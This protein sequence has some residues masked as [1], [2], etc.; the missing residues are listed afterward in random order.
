MRSANGRFV[1]GQVPWNKGLSRLM[2]GDK[3]RCPNCERVLP[4]SG[5]G[6]DRSRPHGKSNEC[7]PCAND[8]RLTTYYRLKEQRAGERP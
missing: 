2:V 6:N 7:R 4:L 8:R 5:F 3:K 1:K